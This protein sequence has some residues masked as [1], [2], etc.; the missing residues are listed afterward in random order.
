MRRLICILPVVF[1]L[2]TQCGGEDVTNLSVR[3]TAHPMGGYNV[4]TVTCMFEA[5]LSGGDESITA[6]VA[7]WWQDTGYSSQT[8]W[9]DQW[10]FTDEEWEDVTTYFQAAPGMVLTGE[11]W[12]VITWNDSEGDDHSTSSNHCFCNADDDSNGKWEISK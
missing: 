7:W 6:T 2:L 3:F 1:L 11:F 10:T 4:S 12:V 8:I 9:S 5:R